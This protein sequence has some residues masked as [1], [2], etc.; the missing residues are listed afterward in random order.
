MNNFKPETRGR[1]PVHDWVYLAV[2]RVR[3]ESLP[4]YIPRQ[5]TAP[6]RAA[7][8]TIVSAKNKTEDRKVRVVFAPDQSTVIF[9]LR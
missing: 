3:A 5:L 2:D 6:G 8:R 1:K 7:V 4:V 9:M